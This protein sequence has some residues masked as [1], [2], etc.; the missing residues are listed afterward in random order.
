MATKVNRLK[1]YDEETWESLNG[2][3][4]GFLH[5]E[6][7]A[8]AIAMRRGLGW[9]LMGLIDRK[10]VIQHA[11]VRAPNEVL[12]DARGKVT[13]E[14][15]AKPFSAQ[16]LAPVTEEKLYATRG[17][18][19]D[20]VIE[21]ARLIAE[22]LWPE[23]AWKSPEVEKAKAFTDELEALCRKHGLWVWGGIPAQQPLISP[24]DK[25]I[26]KGYSLTPTIHGTTFILERCFEY[27]LS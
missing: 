26:F 18:I 8:F 11:L 9:D 15:A 24:L 21:R 4:H 14:E 1:E 13:E 27:P 5:G 23:L 6:C 20:G 7:Y 19:Q 22:T 16:V 17:T 3:T 12:W 10:G 2:M 25:E